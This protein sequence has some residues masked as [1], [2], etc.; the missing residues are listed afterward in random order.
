MADEADGASGDLSPI[1][2]A[3]TGFPNDDDDAAGDLDAA[4]A[5][6]PLAGRSEWH[7]GHSF[8]SAF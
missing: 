2:R 7:L 3:P 8:L 1:G 6:D 4:D 5:E